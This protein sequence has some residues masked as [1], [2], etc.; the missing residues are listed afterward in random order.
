MKK[1]VLAVAVAG[2]LGGI[3][4]AAAS[5]L[6]L[7]DAIRDQ[8]RK[9][10]LALIS[11]KA[12]V[13]A[14][15][16]DGSTP[17]AWAA[18]E[19]DATVVTA[20]LK[21]GAKANV[22]DEYGETPLTQAC[23]NGNAAIVK[24]LLDAGADA[25][26]ARWNGESALMIAAGSG[27]PEVLKQLID[28]GAKV[29]ATESIKGQT[30]LMWA[31][32]HGHAE[33]VDVLIKAG[34]KVNATSKAGFSPLVFA[35]IQGNPKSAES[36][37][38]AGAEV[39]Y[40]V[41][42]GLSP[43][44]VAVTAK[45]NAVADV[46][47]AHGADV[48]AK[49]RTGNTA[50]HIAAQ[51]GDVNLSKALLAKGADVNA[52]TNKQQA[53]GGRGG[54]GF[55]RGPSGEQTPLML[56]ARAN[57]TDVMKAL[58]AAGADPKIRAQDGGTLLMAAAN[59]GHV[60]PVAYAWELDPAAIKA[61][62]ETKSEVMHASVTGSLQVSTQDEVCKVVKFLA[63]KGADLDPLD[64]NG[65]TP[66]MIANVLPIDKAVDLITSLIQASGAEPK[67]KT[68]REDH[69]LTHGVRARHS[70][71]IRT[72]PPTSSVAGSG[73]HSEPLGRR[74][75]AHSHRPRLRS[76][77]HYQCRVRVFARSP[78]WSRPVDP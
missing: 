13:N 11:N 60:D 49:D 69:S 26:A 14:P 66:I 18:H 1:V 15:Q 5:E 76:P 58:V 53:A 36:L 59:S 16:P 39:N 57:H 38:A 30:P 17:L 21:A 25:N 74:V 52:K 47:V 73:C 6:R 54:G 46:L 23:A 50:L 35:A 55:F 37:I 63:D 71:Q 70:D 32:A 65:R 51:L 7:V 9:A 31:V 64:A 24:Q 12:D 29:E 3:V 41:P 56:A 34:A 4:P 19:D 42:A 68:T 77:R 22:A 72:L 10:V 62:T 67:V 8:N 43:L 48:K 61:Q 78:R 44:L 27:N 20:L 40:A 45:R 28:H 33:A 75:R 2:L